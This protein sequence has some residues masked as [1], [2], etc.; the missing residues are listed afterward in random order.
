MS[1]QKYF[2][3]ESG[4][5]SENRLYLGLALHP[6]SQCISKRKRSQRIR[7]TNKAWGSSTT[8]DMD[9][10]LTDQESLAESCSVTGSNNT[11]NTDQLEEKVLTIL[12][13]LKRDKK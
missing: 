7:S 4:N 6:T 2:R 5:K 13:S 3:K 9:L 11:N 8:D 1:T 12:A 10:D